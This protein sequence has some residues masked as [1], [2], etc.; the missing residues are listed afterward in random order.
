MSKLLLREPL[1]DEWNEWLI[2]KLSKVQEQERLLVKQNMGG[3]FN[4]PSKL[5][6]QEPLLWPTPQSDQAAQEERIEIA[7][8]K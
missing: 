4:E 2:C 8:F 5:L 3:S 6:H 1:L 7:A